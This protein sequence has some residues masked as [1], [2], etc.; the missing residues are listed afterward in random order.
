MRHLRTFLSRYAIF[1]ALI[2]ECVVLAA[3]TDSFFTTAN[4]SN[5]LRQNAFIAMLAAGMTFV[6]LTGGIDLSVGSIVG[7]SGVVCAELLSQ[8]VGMA[9]AVAAGVSVGVVVGVVVG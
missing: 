9:P 6:I 5:V 3:T 4:L 7:L 8:H 2:V 1:A